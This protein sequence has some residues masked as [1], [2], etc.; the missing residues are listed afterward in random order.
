MITILMVRS[1]ITY[2]RRLSV[3][4]K[5]PRSEYHNA[6]M[7]PMSQSTV[8]ETVEMRGQRFLRPA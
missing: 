7:M 8:N 5:S 3:G 6:R 1:F 2:D 4:I